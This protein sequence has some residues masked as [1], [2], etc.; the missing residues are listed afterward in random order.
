M[1]SEWCENHQH[2]VPGV[3]GGEPEF[4]GPAPGFRPAKPGVEVFQSCSAA[5][6]EVELLTAH[7]V[8]GDLPDWPIEMVLPAVIINPRLG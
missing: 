5:G 3:A 1:W 7:F 4:A 8:A 2:L 6:G